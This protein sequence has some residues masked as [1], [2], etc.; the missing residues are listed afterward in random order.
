M[1]SKY[2]ETLT[3]QDVMEILQVS[4]N[5]AYEYIRC[6]EIPS[7]KIRNKYII[8]RIGLENYLKNISKV[9]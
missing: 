8:P 2:K 9:Y 5:T 7:K 3:I 4:R 1:L 6:G